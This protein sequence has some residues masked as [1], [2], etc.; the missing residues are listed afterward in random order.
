MEKVRFS[1]ALKEKI[2]DFLVAGHRFVHLLWLLPILLFLFIAIIL[3]YYNILRNGIL[4]FSSDSLLFN[5]T[6]WGLVVNS[7]IFS[8]F[9]GISSVILAAVV[10]MPVGWILG[11]YQFQFKRIFFVILTVPFIT[12]P[13]FLVIGVNSSL[14]DGGIFNTVLQIIGIET[15]SPASGI[16]PVLLAHTYYNAPLFVNWTAASV[17]LLKKDEEEVAILFGSKRFHKFKR[18]Y[19]PNLIRG[20]YPA[21]IFTFLYSVLSFAIVLSFTS[22]RNE[23][24][25][26]LIYI[27]STQFFDFQLGAILAIVQTIFTLLCVWQYLRLSDRFEKDNFQSKGRSTATKKMKGKEFLLLIPVLLLLLFDI[28]PFYE[29][30]RVALSNYEGSFSSTG[31][32]TLNNFINLTSPQTES[33]MKASLI[34][35]ILNTIL[36][37][38]IASSLGILLSI[39]ATYVLWNNV[40]R[41]SQSISWLIMISLGVSS[42]TLALG[43]HIT[44]SRLRI[45]S[46]SLISWILLIIAYT[47]ITLPYSFRILRSGILG[48]DRRMLEVAEILGENRTGVLLRVILPLLRSHISLSFV[49][50]FAVVIGEFSATSFISRRETTTLSIAIYRLFSDRASSIG[51]AAAL[52]CIL[53]TISVI[54]FTILTYIRKKDNTLFF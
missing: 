45:F 8:L 30:L 5:S 53:M 43:L 48:I 49:F 17:G 13:I 4:S 18:Y 46:G 23:T 9:L 52:N 44:Y 34:N 19:L 12:P 1:T 38:I 31:G 25:E 37:G 3:P 22:P 35:I 42:I 54:A 6:L 21:A 41:L 50:S 24:L 20:F 47:T 10:G 33:V 36:F 7:V 32:L 29:T 28:I 16:F 14:A 26:V 15:S 27:I 2:D 51:E 40:D 39:I 11:K